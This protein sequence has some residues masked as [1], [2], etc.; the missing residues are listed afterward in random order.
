MQQMQ[1]N[2]SGKCIALPE[3]RQLQLLSEMVRK[4]GAAVIQVP[5]VSIHDAPDP[6]PVLAW[7]EDF[8]REPPALL[9]LLT[10][11]GLRRLV[12]LANR[13]AL[14]EKFI[15]SLSGVQKLCRGPKPNQAL[16]ELGLE[17]DLDALA[18]TTEGVIATLESLELQG[19]D[20]AVQLYGEEPNLKLI[21]F[22]Q[23]HG[24]SVR[25]VAPYVYADESEDEKVRQLVRDMAA[26]KIDV[27]A[28]TS[29]PQVKRLLQVVRSSDLMSVLQE[30]LERTTI[31]AVGPVVAEVLE[32]NGIHVQIMPERTYFMK[33]MVS[34]IASYLQTA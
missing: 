19:M 23:E 22:L 20:I 12:K 34:A 2:L 13:H 33:P 29:Q 9:I 26:G 27:V 4:R 25:V 11:E 5:L 16:R 30:G 10:G 6:A 3:S 7:L 31:A 14:K 15:A 18:P 1:G 17:R 28:F 8:V 21:N 24:A 32:R